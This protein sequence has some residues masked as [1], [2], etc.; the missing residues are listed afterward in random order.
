M[1]KR[2]GGRKK[3]KLKDLIEYSILIAVCTVFLFTA[4]SYVLNPPPA[5][6]PENAQLKAAIV[7][8]LSI[9]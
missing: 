7:D 2:K 8:Q 6:V 1:V 4:L 9:T 3:R 5:H